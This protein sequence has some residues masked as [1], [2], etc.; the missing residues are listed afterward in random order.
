MKMEYGRWVGDEKMWYI[1]DYE[2]QKISPMENLY[3]KQS[4]KTTAHNK[5]EQQEAKEARD[6]ND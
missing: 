1:W 3:K 6:K 4:L 2:N 5:W